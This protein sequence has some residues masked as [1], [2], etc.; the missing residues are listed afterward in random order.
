MPFV[1][2][3]PAFGYW[4]TTYPSPWI[5]TSISFL[6][7]RF[8]KSRFGV[9]PLKYI[10]EQTEEICEAAVEQNKDAA[11][12]IIDNALQDTVF[13]VGRHPIETMGLFFE[14][15]DVLFFSLK[16]SPIFNLT[17]PAKLQAYMSAGKPVLAML[18][19]EGAN[20][21]SKMW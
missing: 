20:I 1:I 7:S 6:F 11:V 3:V 2:G 4:E 13:C 21:V 12:Y 15:A 19:G 16:D 8:A 5:V 14:K 17:C 18:N 10:N 9:P